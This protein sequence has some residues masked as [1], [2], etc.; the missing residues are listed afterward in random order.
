MYYHDFSGILLKKYF[1]DEKFF[2]TGRTDVARKLLQKTESDVENNSTKARVIKI[3]PSVILLKQLLRTES[4]PRAAVNYISE[5]Y[6]VDKRIPERAGLILF[7]M[8]FEQGEKS[9]FA[10]SV[11]AQVR[12]QYPAAGEQLA[13]LVA[14]NCKGRVTVAS[15]QEDIKKIFTNS[16]LLGR[17]TAAIL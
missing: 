3:S 15:S 8:L 16:S 14:Q 10:A 2:F 4:D 12:A 11:V 13:S 17:Q 5:V 1:N 7:E 6:E 9:E